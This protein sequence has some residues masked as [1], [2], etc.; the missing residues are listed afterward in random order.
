MLEAA[1][2][3]HKL[4][5]KEYKK[6]LP[7]LRTRL[8]LIQQMLTKADFPV[9]ILIS[10][11]DGSGKGAIINRLNKWMDPHYIQTHAFGPPSDE[12]R[13]RPPH[14]RYWLALPPDGHMGIFAGSWYSDPLSR[15]MEGLMDFKQIEKA[16]ARIHKLEEEL[17]KDGALILKYW[18]HLSKTQQR[19][20]FKDL[21]KNPKTRW[22]VTKR[23]LKHLKLYDRFCAIAEHTLK[24]T[25]TTESPWLI[26]NGSNRYYRDLKIGNDLYHRITSHLETR[27]SATAPPPPPLIKP[28]SA[29]ETDRL[30][31]L[32]LTQSLS[33]KSYKTQRKHYQER[34]SQLARQAN[35]NKVSTLL[36]FEGWDAAG[37]GG[38]IR[39][40]TQAL[41]ARQYRVIPF[42]APM[43]EEKAHH[44]LWRFWRHLPRAGRITIYDRSWYGRVLVERIEGL[45]THAEWRRAYGEIN[46]FEEEL[47][48]HGILVIKYWLHISQEEQLRR[49]KER[50]KTP[51]KQ[52]KITEEDYRN[53]EK[54][55]EYQAAA[56]EMI[57]R[58]HT[59]Y[60]P[61]YLIEG[62]DKRFTRIKVLKIFC[63]RLA[64]AL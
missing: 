39:R 29:R 37:K 24:A 12:E 8:L 59:P 4:S 32:D 48:D 46:D 38:A 61:W 53:R 45:A 17:I 56:N 6:V 25:H 58:T 57:A 28:H 21:M 31:G 7:F 51:Y 64:N 22:R 42:A 11:V 13:E 40:I 55:E 49:F 16:L 1:K 30:G 18:L 27:I 5:K 50:E 34:L 33:K 15:Y 47:T 36:V 20:H 35:K 54:W 26:V 9:I 62:N 19:Q 60:A 44:Y 10:G 52:F 3:K 63:E 23:D 14:W 2:Q 43:D 41:D